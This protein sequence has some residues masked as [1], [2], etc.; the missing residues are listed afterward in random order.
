M[1]WRFKVV[2]LTVALVWT[3]LPQLACFLPETMMTAEEH[4]CCK[5]MA[6]D[7]DQAMMPQHQCCRYEIRTDKAI[8]ATHR[9]NHSQVE[10][11][12]TMAAI[13]GFEHVLVHDSNRFTGVALLSSPPGN[14]AQ[15]SSVLRI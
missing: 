12:A 7:C 9:D 13:A 2:A 6:G 15:A 11:P 14:P 3:L 10:M 1:K 8:T 5:R 4:E